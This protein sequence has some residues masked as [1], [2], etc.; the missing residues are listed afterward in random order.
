MFVFDL[1]FVEIVLYVN[2]VFFGLNNYS[3]YLEEK[4]IYIFFNFLILV[5]LLFLLFL[6]VFMSVRILLISFFK[7]I[8]VNYNQMNNVSIANS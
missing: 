6:P 3:E 7:F 2:Y 1:H 8:L 4:K 5:I